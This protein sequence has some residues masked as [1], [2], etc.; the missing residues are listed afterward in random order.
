MTEITHPVRRK[1]SRQETMFAVPC[2][3]LR[4]E[5]EKAAGQRGAL[6]SYVVGRQTVEAEADE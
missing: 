2:P 5:V 4:A 6:G 1:A 3:L